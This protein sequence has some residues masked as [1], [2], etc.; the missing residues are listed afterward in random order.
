MGLNGLPGQGPWA[1][2]ADCPASNHNTLSASLTRRGHQGCTCPRS[3]ELLREHRKK[4]KAR[5]KTHKIR[6]PQGAPQPI[7]A[8]YF[9]DFSGGACTT[10][11]GQKAALAGMNDQA[12][13]K[14]IKDRERAK[15]LCT[16]GPCPILATCRAWVLGQE[17]PEGSWGGVWGGLDPWNRRGLELVIRAGQAETIPFEIPG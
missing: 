5:V 14:A 17:R 12:S 13:L 15:A 8:T 9:P 6:M 4:Y 1:I 16:V 7:T 3:R 11:R 2:D 10:E